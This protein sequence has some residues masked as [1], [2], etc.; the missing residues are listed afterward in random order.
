MTK[1][2]PVKTA[3]AKKKSKTTDSGN[4]KT[5]GVKKAVTLAVK[6]VSKAAA[7]KNGGTAKTTKNASKK[8]EI[9]QKAA[10]K[11]EMPQKKNKTVNAVVEAIQEPIQAGKAGDTVHANKV[12]TPEYIIEM[13]RKLHHE[14]FEK[15]LEKK[16]LHDMEYWDN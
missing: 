14:I 5:A 2:T 11:A 4:G 15:C 16:I 1:K 12:E 3:G 9:V 10:V 13:K 7:G 6:S 8:Q